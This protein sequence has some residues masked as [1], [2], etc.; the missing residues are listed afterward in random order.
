[1][2]S[3]VA[4]SLL[5]LLVLAVPTPLP[6]SDAP[7]ITDIDILNYALTLEHLEN[8]FYSGALAQFGNDAFVHAGL[9]EFARGRFAQIAQHEESHVAFLQGVLGDKAVKPC[10]YNL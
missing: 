10:T 1:M 7:A 5:P 9:P 3:F 8:A 6:R 2:K 4:F